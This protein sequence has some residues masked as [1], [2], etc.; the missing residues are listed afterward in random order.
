MNDAWHDYDITQRDFATRVIE[1]SRRMPVLVDF[2]APWCGP[3]KMLAPLLA[4]LADEY[5]GSIALAKVN[6]DSEPQLAREYGIRALPTVKLFENGRAVDEFMGVLPE[7]GIRAFIERHVER[8]AD[9]MRRKAEAAFEA[10][11]AEAALRWLSQAAEMEPDNHSVKIAT[12][13]VLMRA[14]SSDEAQAILNSLPVDVGL[15]AE[16][17]KLR[18]Q[19]DFARSAG[20]GASYTELEQNVAS[21]P[22]DLQA[23]YC[24]G[25]HK[26]MRGEYGGA[27]EQLLEI[28]RRDRGF[29]NDA[30]RKGMLSIF[31]ILG[32]R[33]ELVNR[34]R[35][36]MVNMLH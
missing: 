9:K 25:A 11:D 26:V 12:A 29:G 3:C 36:K 4:K 35:A 6:T 15:T 13:K 23:R 31:E 16:V 17:K 5:R 24:L 20:Q 18:A 14:G 2:W 1:Q 21:D 27:L 22:G 30:G 8:E 34:Y 10:G 19:L 28:M 32:G 7:S 33:G